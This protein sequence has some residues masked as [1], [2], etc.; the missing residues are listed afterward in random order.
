MWNLRANVFP[1]LA[2]AGGA[3]AA[4]FGLGV[5]KT[6][7]P[8]VAEL[9]AQAP[10][11]AAAPIPDEDTSSSAKTISGEVLER[12]D[13][14]KYTYLRLGEPGSAGTWTAVPR[15]ETV[16]VGQRVRVQ[17]AELM[18][19]FVS[20]SLKRTFDAIYFGVLDA[21][22]G[23]APVAAAAPASPVTPHTS[24]GTSAEAVT[25]PKLARASGPLGRTVAELTLQRA[26]LQ[27][28][29]ARVRAVVVKSIGGI[30]GRTFLH[31][32]DGSGDAATGSND[33]TVTTSA[34]PAVGER[35]L[36]EG[37]VVTDKDYGSGYRYPVLLEDARL[38]AE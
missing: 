36:L 38:L 30:L 27:G 15:A 16:Q 32:R 19:G 3:T 28:K 13:V 20:A 29:P 14:E 23:S 4:L 7:A 21:G 12:I 37:T 10:S 17:S 18:T 9:K 2:V 35:V 31:V 33:L 6:A 5:H 8:A 25:V 24:I 34:S 1:I 11:P 22:A 26:S